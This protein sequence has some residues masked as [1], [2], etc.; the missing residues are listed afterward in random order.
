MIPQEK[1]S[2]QTEN[3]AINIMKKLFSRSSNPYKAYL[4]ILD[5][6]ITEKSIF[7]STT[8]GCQ[9]GYLSSK[10]EYQTT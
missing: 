7:T 2:Q 8:W 4:D 3:N 5:W 1:K 10:E 9:T 6:I